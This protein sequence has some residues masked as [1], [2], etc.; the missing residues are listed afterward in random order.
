MQAIGKRYP[1]VQALTDVDF[2]VHAGE[3]HALLGENGAGKSTLMGV[4]A[5]HVRPDRGMITIDGQPVLLPT[6]RHALA[7]GIGMVHQHALASER[8]SV[9]E[10]IAL[11]WPRLPFWPRRRALRA[12]IA[13]AVERYSLGIEAL[14]D[15]PMHALP[16]G[17]RQKVE[18]ARAL[19]HEA[20]VLV[21]DEPTA[22][23]APVEA[24]AL[25]ALIARFCQR[26]GGVVFI[27][28]KLDEVRAIADRITVLR[29][30][31]RVA[32]YAGIDA[33]GVDAARLASDMMGVALGSEVAS[34]LSD[35]RTSEPSPEATAPALRL[36]NVSLGDAAASRGPAGE[37]LA[38][39]DLQ[40]DGGRMLGVAGVAGSGQRALAELLAG[41]HRPQSGRFEL[42]G[43]PVDSRQFSPRHFADAGVAYIP[44]DRRERGIA[45]PLSVADNLLLRC[46]RRDF[47][48]AGVFARGRARRFADQQIAAHDIRCPSRDTPARTLSGGNV[49]KLIAGR[50]LDGEPGLIV[51]AYPF[52][53]L[54]LGAVSEVAARLRAA[55]A[56]GAAVVLISEDVDHLLDLADDVAVLFRGRIIATARCADTDAATLGLWMGGEAP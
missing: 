29:H 11:G 51:A 44:E 30:G 4:L 8:H 16:V 19:L 15:A 49:Q 43:R 7:H 27:S 34:P 47:T 22:V 45:G 52:R 18:I 28:H 31:R 13:A 37:R 20:R 40:L 12:H 9:L 35:A 32:H 23:L 1:G 50:E 25:F 33:R 17:S 14:L 6:P 55:Q 21:F 38:D 46:Y 36:H 26:G 41:H 3:V 39:I 10:N 42:F 48:R 53:G 54:D 56:R 5:G 24:E 2:A